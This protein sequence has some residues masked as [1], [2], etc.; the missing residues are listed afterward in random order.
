MLSPADRRRIDELYT[1]S[2]SYADRELAR[3]R[4]RL[5]EAGLWDGAEIFLLTDHGEGFEKGVFLEHVNSLYEPVT[6]IAFIWK[7]ANGESAGTAIDGPVESIDLAPTILETAGI[8]P[9]R[10]FEGESLVGAANGGAGAAQTA[11]TEEP[12][13]AAQ[14]LVH[15]SERNGMI[16]SSPAGEPHGARALRA[17]GERLSITDGRWKYIFDSRGAAELYDLSADP[18]EARNLS[19]APPPGAAALEGLLGRW[20]KEHPIPSTGA[21][22]VDEE[23]RKLLES[24]GYL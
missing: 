8:P 3:L 1:A 7:R 15:L 21:E 16:F 5:E 6:R 11:I 13:L 17:S 2:I 20:R 9:P 12:P 22:P 4:G 10:S 19:D 14:Q 18:E 24:L 23:T